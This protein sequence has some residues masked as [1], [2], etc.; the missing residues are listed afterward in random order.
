MDGEVC[1][2]GRPWV[3]SVCER[4]PEPERHFDENKVAERLREMGI[5]FE[6]VNVAY[7]PVGFPTPA[8]F[9][10]TG[11]QCKLH[12][13]AEITYFLDAM[14]EAPMRVAGLT[15]PEPVRTP[16]FVRRPLDVRYRGT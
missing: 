16:L 3:L 5:A 1:E 12:G 8:L 6:Q 4:A 10:T 15:L 9:V 13:Y 14:A 11:I 2:E 7:D